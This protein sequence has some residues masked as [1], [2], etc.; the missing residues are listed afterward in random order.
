MSGKQNYKQLYTRPLRTGRLDKEIASLV[1]T[2][3]LRRFMRTAE[4]R[5]V[6]ADKPYNFSVQPASR[7]E[8]DTLSTSTERNY[9]MN[10]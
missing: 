9:V 2:R 8:A 6:R 10:Q 3:L 5:H 1:E 7:N 4:K